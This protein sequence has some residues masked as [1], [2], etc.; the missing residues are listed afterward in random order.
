MKQSSTQ[1]NESSKSVS[2]R[3]YAELNDFLSPDRRQQRF[4]YEFKGTPAVKDLIEAIGVPHTEIDL[5]LVNNRSVGFDYRITPGDDIAVYPV[6][7]SMDIGPVTRLRAAP[8][9]EP[10]FIA[11]INLGRLARYLRMLGF[12]TLYRNDFRDEQII[13]IALNEHRII[14]T[15]DQAILKHKRVTHGY[16]VRH[17]RILSQLQEVVNRF[18]LSGSITPFSRCMVCNGLVTPVPKE[19][20]LSQ[21]PEGTKRDFN[22]FYRCGSCGKVYWKGS[23]YERM[24]GV[25]RSTK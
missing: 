24:M 17:T 20:I 10:Q 23:H 3:F 2:I 16:W 8:M 19:H 7:E 5:I 6:F 1:H 22:E 25:V 14:L 15:R 18:D 13:D 9:R 12:D 21:L 11:D 4:P